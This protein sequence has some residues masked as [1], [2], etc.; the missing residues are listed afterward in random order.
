MF[1]W[2]YAVVFTMFGWWCVAF[3]MFVRLV[4]SACA[5]MGWFWAGAGANFGPSGAKFDSD[6]VCKS[7][8]NRGILFGWFCEVF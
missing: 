1:G 3:T 6:V 7:A 2:W 5:G 4:G 8:I